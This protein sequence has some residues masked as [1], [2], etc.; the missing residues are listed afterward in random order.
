[1]RPLVRSE[2]RL[3][4][5]EHAKGPAGEWGAHFIVRQQNGANGEAGVSN[6]IHDLSVSAVINELKQQDRQTRA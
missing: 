3:Y 6:A 5:P 2:Y 4:A 1:V